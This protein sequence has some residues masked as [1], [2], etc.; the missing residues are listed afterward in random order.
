MSQRAFNEILN[1]FICSSVNQ[2]YVMFCKCIVY[3]HISCICCPITV[4][5]PDQD[6]YLHIL[7]IELICKIQ[8]EVV[9]YNLYHSINYFFSRFLH[10]L[11]FAFYTITSRY[12]ITQMYYLVV[13][14]KFS[15]GCLREELMFL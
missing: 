9:Y 2:N 6:N 7:V 11:N 13:K 5:L 12:L 8:I 14:I 10:N 3:S 4:Y 1:C 15:I